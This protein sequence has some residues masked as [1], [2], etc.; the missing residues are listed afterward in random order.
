MTK[1]AYTLPR[2]ARPVHPLAVCLFGFV[3]CG[4]ALLLASLYLA[5]W[6]DV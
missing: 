3:L 2:K 1:N 5:V 6:L 4:P